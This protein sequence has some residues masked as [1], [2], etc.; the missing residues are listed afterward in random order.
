MKRELLGAL[1][2]QP[3]PLK[4]CHRAVMVC[5]GVVLIFPGLIILNATFA[6]KHYI[7]LALLLIP[8][9]LL[10]SLGCSLFRVATVSPAARTSDSSPTSS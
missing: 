8:I 4:T 5:L 3:Q 6:N 1:V 9:Y 10:I 7:A 2:G